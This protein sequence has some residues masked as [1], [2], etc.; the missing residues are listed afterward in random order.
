MSDGLG[1]GSNARA[2]LMTRGMAEITRLGIVAGADRLTFGGLAGVGDLIATCSSTRSRNHHV[3]HELALGRS[4]D[5]IV[6]EMTMV[7]EGIDTTR[8]VLVLAKRL[9]VEMPITQGINAVLRGKQSVRAEL[10]HL[11]SRPTGD[12]LERIARAKCERHQ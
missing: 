3:G 1:F 10:K 7:A 12:E 8:G 6:A 5:A 2:S 9:G 11:M 4:L